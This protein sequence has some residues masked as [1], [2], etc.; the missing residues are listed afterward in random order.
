M[1]F[2]LAASALL[3]FQS[4]VMAFTGALPDNKVIDPAPPARSAPAL[5]ELKGVVSWA[6]LADVRSVKQKDKI[7]PGFSDKV[8]ALDKTQV[9][10]QGFMIPLEGGA[11]Q[12]RFLLSSTSPTCEFCIPGGP[13]SLVEVH[14][15]R[16]FEYTTAPIIVSGKFVVA[17]ND[18][19]GVLYRLTEADSTSR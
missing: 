12:K 5:S 17:G 18:G 1:K 11:S 3:L 19:D 7:V 2:G 16:A 10:V 8:I 6:T 13:E 4:S 14:A 9:K 15:K